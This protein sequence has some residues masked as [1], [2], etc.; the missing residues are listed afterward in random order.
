LGWTLGIEAYEAW[1]ARLGDG[2]CSPLG[3]LPVDLTFA[4]GILSDPMN[5][6]RKAAVIIR[7]IAQ[8]ANIAKSDYIA[9]SRSYREFLLSNGFRIYEHDVM[10]KEAEEQSERRTLKLPLFLYV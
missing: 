9:S 5:A 1:M 4:P 10:F 7:P 8:C 2:L 6:I 3:W